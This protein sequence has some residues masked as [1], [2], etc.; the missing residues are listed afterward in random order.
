M[1]KVVSSCLFALCCNVHIIL[2]SH[3]VTC[4]FMELLQYVSPVQCPSPIFFLCGTCIWC[5]T[6]FDDTKLPRKGCPRCGANNNEP[7]PIMSNESFTF[8]YSDK[9]GVELKFMLRDKLFTFQHHTV[10]L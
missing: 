7:L 3:K 2:L 1:I 6:Y 9:R 10:C 8:N 5:A 4:F